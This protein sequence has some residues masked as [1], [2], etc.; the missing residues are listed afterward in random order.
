MSL[1]L[2]LVL[3]AALIAAFVIGYRAGLVKFVWKIAALIMTVA[4][5]MALTS[6]VSNMLRETKMAQTIHSGIAENVKIPQG[7]GVNIAENLNL[8]MFA[9]S[10]VNE[11]LEDAQ[12]AVQSVNDT[13]AD[14]LTDFSVTVITCVGLFILI[15][16]LLMA[17]FMIINAIAKL[18]L[19]KSANKL[20]G[21][22]LALVNVVFAVFL[23]LALVS[24]FAPAESTMFA[25]IENTYIVKYFYNYNILLKLFMK[26]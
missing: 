3:V 11:R 25:A 5:V 10:M 26:I 13:A 15:R 19:V 24:L 23:V 9:Q 14:V 17:V 7:G 8:P 18:P 4:L 1:I 20:T 12:G 2:D 6:P 22:L 21:A 16:L